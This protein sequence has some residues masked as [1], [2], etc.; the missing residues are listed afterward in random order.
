MLVRVVDNDFLN[1]RKSSGTGMG[2]GLVTQVLNIVMG[3]V[4]GGFSRHIDTEC[5]GWLQSC[6]TRC[7]RAYWLLG[8]HAYLC[9]D[10]FSVHYMVFSLIS[11]G[12]E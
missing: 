3:G 10:A 5:V 9:G 4:S 2:L 7:D 12:C 1:G 6:L 8:W 11:Y